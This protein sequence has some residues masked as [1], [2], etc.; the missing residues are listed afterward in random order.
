[1]KSP[2]TTLRTIKAR[3]CRL[4][5]RSRQKTNSS[6]GL[7]ERGHVSV[8]GLLPAGPHGGKTPAQGFIWTAPVR[9]LDSGCTI[10]LNAAHARCW[11]QRF[12]IAFRLSPGLCRRNLF[13]V[14]LVRLQTSVCR[15]IHEVVTNQ[16]FQS[17]A[18]VERRC[19]ANADNTEQEEKG[20]G[21]LGLG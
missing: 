5:P 19:C 11:T 21:I 15:M 16:H 10:F 13:G 9:L 3:S 20:D 4:K 18:D 7:I 14:R 6:S 12:P 8:V 17:S 2:R 1:M